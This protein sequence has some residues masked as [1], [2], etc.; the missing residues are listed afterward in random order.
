[1]EERLAKRQAK[2][3]TVSD[4]RLELLDSQISSWQKTSHLPRENLLKLNGG[5]TENKKLRQLK[6]KLRE[7]GH[8][9]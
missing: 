3:H 7:M 8:G 6:D 5:Q 9:H 1:L 4:G 2:V